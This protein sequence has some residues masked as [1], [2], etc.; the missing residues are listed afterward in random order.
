METLRNVFPD[1]EVEVI[2]MVLLAN[3]GDV[4]RTIDSLLEMI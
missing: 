1:T 2:E 3:S 4:P